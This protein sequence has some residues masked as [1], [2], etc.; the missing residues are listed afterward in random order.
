MN[1]LLTA[2]EVFPF[3]K[4]GGLGDVCGSLPKEWEKLGHQCIVVMPKYANIDTA[5]WNIQPTNITVAVPIDYWTE[6]TRLWRGT[7]PGSNVQVYFLENADYFDRWGIYGNPEGFWD[8]DRRFIFLCRAVFEVA[9]AL[10]FTPDVIMANDWHTAFTMP[11]LKMRYRFTPRFSRTAGVYAIHNMAFQGQMDPRR[12]LPFAGIP[13]WEFYQGSWFESYGVVNAM[14]VGILFADKIVT[15]SPRYA[16]EIR[17]T[18]SGYGLQGVINSRGGDFIGILN[19]IDENEWNPETDKHI[20]S[21]YS[22]ERLDGKMLNKYHYL[23]SW[24]IEDHEMKEDMPMI[25][26]VTRLTD[27]KGIPLVEEALE[28]ILSNYPVRFTIVGSGAD[29]YENYFRYIGSKFGKR[30]LVYMGYN[31]DLAH[32]VEASADMFLMP[33]LFEPCGLNQMYSLKY[34]TVPVVRAVGGLADT[35]REYNYS[36]GTGNGFVFYDYEAADMGWALHRAISAYFDKPN[37]IRIIKN[38]M[39]ENNS[40]TQSAERYIEVFRWAQEKIPPF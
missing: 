28:R 6:Y 34:G 12:A 39:M 29:R 18:S 4:T 32:K 33:S 7:L 20:F 26:M 37:W 5:K 19:G 14:Q 27:Q 1:I 23:R 3:A 13:M 21:N 15:V 10:N 35:V 9:Q 17:Y 16:T 11:M 40:A 22:R 36:T 25:G 8:N 2:A 30:A 38:G 31:D 24:G